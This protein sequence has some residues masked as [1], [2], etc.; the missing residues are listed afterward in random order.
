M[1][2][3][4]LPYYL[5]FGT[6]QIDP[7]QPFPLHDPNPFSTG[8][9][10]NTG[11]VTLTG[12][13]AYIPPIAGQSIQRTFVL[14]ICFRGN[15]SVPDI[16][17]LG[18]D[19]FSFN[20]FRVWGKPQQKCTDQQPFCDDP[21][22]VAYALYDSIP[23]P[24]IAWAVPSPINPK[25]YA[26]SLK[27]RKFL[28]PTFQGLNHLNA[29][30]SLAWA[31]LNATNNSYTALLGPTTTTLWYW[32]GNNFYSWNTGTSTVTGILLD[33]TMTNSPNFLR[34]DTTPLNLSGSFNI[35]MS[36]RGGA[37]NRS[38]GVFTLLS[39]SWGTLQIIKSWNQFIVSS[40]TTLW[41]TIALPIP[42]LLQPNSFYTVRFYKDTTGN[43]LDISDKTWVVLY[44]SLPN[45]TLLGDVNILYIW[46][47][48]DY[49]SQW[50]DIINFI[51]IWK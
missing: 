15:C 12:V 43:Y 33:S 11:T 49:T 44:R 31:T 51:K 48:F 20:H 50:N 45:T 19:V 40:W 2:P 34:Y 7:N 29:S 1:S 5:S 39:N 8:T 17:V 30:M 28:P 32:L 13:F 21:N 47:K 10:S 24:T 26:L 37:L 23:P 22:L 14:R 36:V 42:S 4:F 46:S 27:N 25:Y 18:E 6:G 16:K 35:E 41:P 38:T 9:L 3:E